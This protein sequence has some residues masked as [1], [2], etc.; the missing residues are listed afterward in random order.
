MAKKKPA[1]TPPPHEEPST[2]LPTITM[3][4]VDRILAT[5]D[6]VL[7]AWFRKGQ[8]EA[9]RMKFSAEQGNYSLFKL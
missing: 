4:D 8:E 1:T 7:M 3:A 2:S 5:P 6:D 9:K